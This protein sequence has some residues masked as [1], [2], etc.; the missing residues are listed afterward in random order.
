ML[1]IC[2]RHSQRFFCHLPTSDSYL[3]DRLFSSDRCYLFIEDLP[4]SLDLLKLSPCTY[5]LQPIS[6]HYSLMICRITRVSHSVGVSSVMITRPER[7]SAP[8]LC[9]ANTHQSINK[10]LLNKQICECTF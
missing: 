8:H 4:E 7:T 5:S 9:H 3:Y 6:S 1:S 10:Q 2:L